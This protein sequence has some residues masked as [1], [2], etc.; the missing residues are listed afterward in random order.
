MLALA[1]LVTTLYIW[2]IGDAQ[3]GFKRFGLQLCLWLSMGY[4]FT[5]CWVKTGQTLASKTWKFKVTDAEG[6]LLALPMALK[7]YALACVLLL[8]A[9]LTFWWALFDKEHCF[10][11]DRLLGTRVSLVS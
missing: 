5:R 8:P 10:L 6:R 4:Y 2:L 7:R 1:A 9:G 11:H 3:T